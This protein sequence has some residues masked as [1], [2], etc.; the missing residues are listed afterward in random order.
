MPGGSWNSV[1][2]N[3]SDSCGAIEVLVG[4]DGRK[5]DAMAIK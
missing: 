5:L 3:L 1:V 2:G 4:K